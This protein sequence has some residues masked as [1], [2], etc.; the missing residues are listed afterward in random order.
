MQPAPAGPLQ[1]PLPPGRGSG[2]G[3]SPARVAR[4]RLHYRPG[5]EWMAGRAGDRG[6]WPARGGDAAA[7]VES[8][9]GAAASRRPPTAW[10][11]GGAALQRRSS[12]PGSPVGVKAF[13]WLHRLPPRKRGLPAAV[14]P[15]PGGRVRVQ[16]W[17]A[18]AFP[19]PAGGEITQFSS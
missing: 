4:G 8:R 16:T 9:V 14:Q 10:L 11:A 17:A 5:R 13:L 12:P 18:R 1:I 7:G 6:P 3:S 19:R 15:K 2:A